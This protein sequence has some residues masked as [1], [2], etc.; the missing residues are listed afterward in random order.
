MS[1]TAEKLPDWTPRDFIDRV[2]VD[3]GQMS[4]N[5][6]AAVLDVSAL[7]ALADYRKHIAE[8]YGTLKAAQAILGNILHH[9]EQVELAK[10][11][12]A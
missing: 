7:Y 6:H 10:K 2:Q 11:R 8:N 4:H 5:V 3:A 1:N 12:A 9:M